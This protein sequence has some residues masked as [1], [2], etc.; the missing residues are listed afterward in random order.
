[1]SSNHAFHELRIDD[2]QGN[3]NRLGVLEVCIRSSILDF[4]G[5]KR[6]LLWSLLCLAHHVVR[7]WCSLRRWPCGATN[8]CRF[9]GIVHVSFPYFREDGCLLI[10]LIPFAVS[11]S[12]AL[13]R[14]R[15]ISRH[16]L[17]TRL[18]DK[19]NDRQRER[20][21]VQL[22]GVIFHDAVLVFVEDV[23]RKGNAR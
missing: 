8:P 20:L 9:I 12:P 21:E 2:W 11:H 13:A 14:A 18:D 4:R 22:G 17:R 16:A 1:M 5:H 3:L 10:R 23:A 15:T 7:P 6:I 19:S